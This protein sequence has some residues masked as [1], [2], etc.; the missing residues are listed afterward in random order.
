MKSQKKMYDK[1]SVKLSLLVLTSFLVMS[2]PL[3]C[4]GLEISKKIAKQMYMQELL[5]V[6]SSL[7]NLLDA[8]NTGDYIKDNNTFYK[9]DKELSTIEKQLNSIS[10]D[11]KVNIELYYGTECITSSSKED[12]IPITESTY[13]T[14]NKTG[15]FYQNVSQT[16]SEKLFCYFSPL[17]QPSSG[18][19]IGAVCVGV[20]TSS[21]KR[22]YQSSLKQQ[23]TI[24]TISIILIFI[25]SF[26]VLS[27]VA[28]ALTEISCELMKL[29]DGNLNI[30]INSAY[31]NQR[32]EIGD[33]S[34]ATIH[35]RDSY[36]LVLERISSLADDISTFS[37]NFTQ[38]FSEIIENIQYSTNAVESIAQG[39]TSQAEETQS[40]NAAIVNLH[41][42]IEQ[43]TNNVSSLEERT[44]SMKDCS[45]YAQKTL[46]ELSAI[47]SQTTSSFATVKKMTDATHS[48][49]SE[50][51]NALKIITDIASQTN[52]LSLN[53]SIEAA[54]A[55][56]AGNGFAVVADE[57][58][59]LAEQ[60]ANMAK[61]IEEITK[62]LT[63]NS[64]KSVSEI[65]SV[66]EVIKTQNTKLNETSDYFKNLLKEVSFVIEDISFI[67]T[68]T[69]VIAN[70]TTA[71]NQKT[72]NLS[73]IAEENAAHTQ[74]TSATV[75]S[76]QDI[77]DKCNEQSGQMIELA[78]SLKER[79][80]KFI[81]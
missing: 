53:A 14:L 42:S 19:I 24:S 33:I 1:I 17:K 40:A 7:Q 11:S 41:Q 30:E 52:L 47:N 74:E 18:E 63:Y 12:M 32:D 58:R 29:A 34:S 20:P 80:E 27:K 51:N 43:T 35:V 77:I 44:K 72:Q 65:D 37:T 50:I 67:Q 60:S 10:K 16:S 8:G 54:R 66:S 2:A 49:V 28:K 70:L 39:V 62:Q 57:I 56:D 25:L 78:N 71:L 76:L 26:N 46:D 3:N 61:Q 5:T 73:T 69:S 64:A 59:Q 4:T 75:V 81:F 13:Q 38:S 22:I 9:G 23:T 36:R 31:Q 6:S 45:I 55:G 15:A 79:T 68:E 21:F 48:S